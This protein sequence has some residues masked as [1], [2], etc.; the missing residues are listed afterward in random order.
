MNYLH[1]GEPQYWELRYQDEISNSR[2]AF[3]N[4]DWY[5]TF[6]EAYPTFEGVINEKEKNDVL[7]LGVGKSDVIEVLYKKG[8]RQIVA[9]DI[10]PT[11]IANMRSQ[12]KDYV[13]VEFFVMDARELSLLQDRSFSIVIDKGCFDAQFCGPNLY[14][15]AALWCTEVYRVL[16]D[17]GVCC[18]FSHAPL[19]ARI[20]YLRS[21][22]WA[23]DNFPIAEGD[24]L[25]MY[26][27]TK[28]NNEERLLRKFPG[29]EII[30]PE[31]VVSKNIVSSV[32]QKQNKVSLTRQ[33]GST[34][35]V[36]VSSSIDVLAKMI[37]DNER[38]MAEMKTSDL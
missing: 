32:V 36:T 26:V 38:Q 33:K 3:E 13:G 35:S 29:A 8:F 23:I 22:P 27:L 12:Y 30:S 14:T 4:F 25:N 17:E 1:Y 10:S 6:K 11:I 21:K 9:V 18:L 2:G 24:S 5:I 28:T 16:K 15:D 7:I 34:G 19:P 20:P 37:E 31:E